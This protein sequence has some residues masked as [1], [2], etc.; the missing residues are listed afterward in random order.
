MPETVDAPPAPR[1]PVT[2][3]TRP[4]LAVLLL[5][6]ASRIVTTLVVTVV[7]LSTRGWS[8]R[9]ADGGTGVLGLL[10]S[11]DGVWFREIATQGYPTELP[12]DGEGRV[13]KN[14]WAFLALYPGVVRALMGLTGLPFEVAGVAVSVVAGGAAAVVLHRL[15]VRRVGP[16]AAAWGTV[17]FCANPFSV[18]LQAT[19]AESLALLCTFGALLA[20]DRRRLAAFTVLTVLAAATRPGALA[21]SAVLVVA[22]VLRLVRGE[23]PPLREHLAIWS[24]VV[25]TTAAG[26]AWPVVADLVTGTSGAYL[27]TETAWWRSYV[28][29]EGGFVPFTP[30]FVMASQWLGPVG[31]VLVVLGIGAM[32]WAVLFRTRR[33]GETLLLWSGAHVGYLVAVFLPQ[34]ST[35]RMLLPLSPLFGQPWLSATRRRALVVLGTCLAL[36]PVVVLLLWVVW[37]P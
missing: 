3:R 14:A 8:A 7:E 1:L 9:E 18:V 26:L 12:T 27:L 22:T 15:L 10:S 32:A 36:Q 30:W 33:M 23:R 29:H 11:W 37:P 2:L 16:R 24:T 28:D 34:H 19:Y 17:F 4:W 13:V 20:L 5:W 31:P 21:L 25:V 35:F 6:V